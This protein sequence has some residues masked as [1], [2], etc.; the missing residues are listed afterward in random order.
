MGYT[1]RVHHVAPILTEDLE[2]VLEPEE[3]FATK[4]NSEIGKEETLVKWKNLAEEEA[5]WEPIE[6]L[7][8]QFSDF[9]LGDK[10]SWLVNTYSRRCKIGNSLP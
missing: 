5:M 3:I 4:M 10:V 7:Q 6:E 8:C 2:W 9:Y 1:T